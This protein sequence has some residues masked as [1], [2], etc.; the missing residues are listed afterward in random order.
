MKFYNEILQWN[1]TMKFYKETF[2]MKN[3]Y[4]IL[5]WNFAMN[6]TMNEKWWLTFDQKSKFCQKN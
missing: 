3:Y 5:Q 2:T 4:E 6:F 1:F